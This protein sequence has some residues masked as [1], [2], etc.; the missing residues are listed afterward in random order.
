ML[1]LYDP[2]DAMYIQD[3][4]NIECVTPNDMDFRNCA[5]FTYIDDVPI[6]FFSFRME[7]NLPYLV[8]LCVKRE[9]RS[10]KVLWRMARYLKN[11]IRAFGYTKAIINTP[12]GENYLSRLVSRYFK[13]RPY[14]DDGVVQFYLVEV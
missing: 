9:N 10:P 12:K 5:T 1:H 14:A 8:H 2:G 7:H 11:V 13:V 4:L 6:G 3:M